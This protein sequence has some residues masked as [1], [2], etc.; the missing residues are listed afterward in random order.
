M[1]SLRQLFTSNIVYCV[2]AACASIAFTLTHFTFNNKRNELA[3]NLELIV[4]ANK[5]AL[6][7]PNTGYLAMQ[8]LVERMQIERLKHV[9]FIVYT[10]RTGIELS[11]CAC[12]CCIVNIILIHKTK[13]SG[14]AD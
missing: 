10:M 13:K 5:R 1:K 7:N 8:A 4:N 12:L 2:V 11:A 3:A 9:E 6:I 14:I